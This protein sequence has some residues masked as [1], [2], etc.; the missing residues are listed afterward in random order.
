[1]SNS[2]DRLKALSSKLEEKKREKIAVKE[3]KRDTA[4]DQ[5]PPSEMQDTP[6]ETGS[7]GSV[8]A[9][10]IKRLKALYTILGIYE[11]SP[12]FDR[13]FRCNN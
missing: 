6:I 5:Q 10:N 11:K 8:R 1:M 4:S 7:T 2:L 3:V 13:I 9:E 12:D